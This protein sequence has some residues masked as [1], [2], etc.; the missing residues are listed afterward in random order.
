ME[1]ES[2]EINGVLV[3][4]LADAIGLESLPKL[5]QTFK[6]LLEDDTKL[7]ILNLKK[8]TLIGSSGAGAIVNLGRELERLKG[9]LVLTE[10]SEM[11]LRVFTLLQM[12]DMFPVFDTEKEAIKS[13]QI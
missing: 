7:V 5:K 11:C 6:S 4:R 13:F 8:V 2:E 12:L 1:I 3:L 10:L 9:R